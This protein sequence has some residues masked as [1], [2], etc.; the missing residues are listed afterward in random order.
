MW[1]RNYPFGTGSTVLSV[2]RTELFTFAEIHMLQ[3]RRDYS[4][5]E[6]PGSR[7]VGTQVSDTTEGQ[8]VPLLLRIYRG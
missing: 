5:I 2:S 7:A 3:A 8:T 1:R 4:I 6:P